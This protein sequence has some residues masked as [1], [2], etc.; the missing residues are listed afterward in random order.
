MSQRNGHP[1][2]RFLLKDSKNKQSEMMVMKATRQQQ[3]FFS[4]NNH[5]LTKQCCEDKDAF[6]TFEKI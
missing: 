6:Q 3:A 2:S 5:G 1:E 4:D